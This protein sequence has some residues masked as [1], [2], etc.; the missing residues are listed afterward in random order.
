LTPEQAEL[1]RHERRVRT[2]F[3]RI[4]TTAPLPVPENPIRVARKYQEEIKSGQT[5]NFAGVARKY[6]V[7]RAE[8]CYHVALVRRLPNDFV[9]WLE[10]CED[11]AVLRVC[12]ERRLRPITKIADP[13]MQSRALSH[14]TLRAPK[15]PVPCEYQAT[16]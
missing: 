2:P 7:S 8:V 10:A 9:T 15:V 4:R 1:L 12:T 6:G 13:E 14:L 16:A 3:G 11:P 5:A